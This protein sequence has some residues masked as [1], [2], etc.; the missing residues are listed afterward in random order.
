MG[1]IGEMFVCV[2]CLKEHEIRGHWSPDMIRE[3]H[4]RDEDCERIVIRYLE[5]KSRYERRNPGKH[6]KACG[7]CFDEHIV[8]PAKNR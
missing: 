8:K 7:A 3:R 4:K 1:E 6:F 2:M 5:I